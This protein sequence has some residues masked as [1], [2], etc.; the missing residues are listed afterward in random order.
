[1]SDRS[2]LLLTARGLATSFDTPAGRLK[3]VDGVDLDLHLGEVVCLVGESGSGK[4]VTGLSLM[5][6][7]DPP[8]HVSAEA[9]R[10][11]GHDLMVL[12]ESEMDRLRGREMAMIFQEPLS[13][14]NP[15]RRVGDQIAEVLRVHSLASPAEATSRA[16]AMLAE[17]GIEDAA[18]R[19]RAYPH[20]L[21]GGQRQRV[22]IAIA[23]IASPKLIIADEPTT[24]LDVTVQAQVL[25]LL[26]RMQTRL[27]S[28][29][30]FITH[31]LGIVAEIADRVLV[32]YAGQVVEE[33]A[34]ADLY[35]APAHPY[36][37]GLLASVPN[38]DSPRRRG[39]PLPAIPGRVPDLLELGTGCRYRD[40]CAQAYDRCTQEPPMIDLADGRRV[41]CWLHAG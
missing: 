34:V 2:G 24:A 26:M 9:L 17:V 4:S 23:C 31:D 6:L 20:Q 30:L 1:V 12:P 37:G 28:G 19:A 8:G 5:R 18:A 22:T 33:A 32:L 21:S 40:R 35:R 7:V 3:A 11:A 27:G 39:L 15:A 25:D 14:L 16:V 13:A 36:T 38:I 29:L 41:R 10:F